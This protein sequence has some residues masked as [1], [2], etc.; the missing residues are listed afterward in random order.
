MTRSYNALFKLL[1]MKRILLVAVGFL[2]SFAA[3]AQNLLWGTSTNGG[4]NNNGVL[5][6][7]DPNGTVVKKIDFDSLNT[8][9][10]PTGSLVKAADGKLYGLTINGGVSNQ[11]VLFQYDPFTSTFSKK[12]DFNGIA[13][14]SKPM[15]QLVLAT[16]GKLYGMTTIGGTKNKGVV[17][18]FDPVTAILTKKID[19]EGT[20]NGAIPK[21]SLIQGN[22]GKLYG[23]T[24]AGGTSNKGVIFQYDL[25]SATLT[26]KF[27][28]T[29]FFTGAEPHGELLQAADGNLYG[30]TR[31]G[32]ASGKGI[33]FQY[34]LT[35]SAFTKKLD[36]NGTERG[37][38]PYGALIQ[39]NDGKLY[40]LTEDGGASNMGVIFQYDPITSTY[41]K[42]LNFN[43][44]DNGSK[45]SGSFLL[46]GDGKY[47]ATT[48][49][50]GAN[51]N[52]VLFQYDV[53]SL[54]YAKKADFSFTAT[55]FHPVDLTEAPDHLILVSPISTPVCAGSSLSITYTTYGVFNAG[56][57]FT[58][59]LSDASGSFSAATSIG[60]LTSTSS[61]AISA[62]VPSITPSGTAY[63]IRVI[64]ANPFVT[65]TD[66]GN[67]ITI[68]ALPAQ[69]GTFTISSASVHRGQNAVVYEVPSDPSATSY[70]WTYSGSGATINGSGNSVTI[71]FSLSAT[72]GT[73]T[74]IPSSN[75]CT[76]PAR[77]LAVSIGT[78]AANSSQSPY[79]LPTIPGGVFTALLTAGDVVSGYKMC[80][81]PDGTGA[82]D[83]ANGTFT[84]LMNHEFGNTA[85]VARAHGAKGAFVS[86]WIVN[87]SDL[88]V[89][90][91]SDLIQNVK[92]WNGSGYSTYNASNPSP[93]TAFNRFC[94][95]D[96]PAVSAF[97]NS[98]TGLG[99]QERIFMNGEE[100]GNE[101]RALA[102]IATG[103]EAGTTYELP[104]LGKLSWEN[105]VA[106]P[107]TGDK[108]LVA[109]LDDS[110][111][112]QVYFYIGT[113]TNSGTD[114][115]K[116]G[117]SN[118]KLFGIAVTG[119]VTETNAS[120]PSPDAPFTLA[121]LGQVQNLTGAVINTNSNNLGITTFLRPEDG[122][123]DPSHPGDFYFATTNAFNSPS[124]LWK[125]HF[126]DIYNPELGGTITAVLDGTEG[127]QMLDNL[128][129][130]NSGH[131]LL[132]EDV[133]GNA[134]LGKTW[135][136]TIATDE[137]KQVGTHDPTR[138]LNGAP[139]FLTQDE[140]A[141]GIVDVQSILGP[142]MFIVV[143][144]AHYGIA[145]EVVEGGQLLAYYNPDSYNASPL[146]F[147][148]TGG[149]NYC[150]GD[151]TGVEIG[152]SH[153]QIDVNYQ[154]IQNDSIPVGTTVSGSG[155]AI[156]FG[157]Q[158]ATGTYTVIATSTVNNTSANM[159][160][161]AVIVINPLPSVSIT[162]EGDTNI[163]AADSVLLA[164]IGGVSGS[165]YLW[166]N[167]KTT[168]SIY[169][170]TSGAYTVVL[171]DANGCSS[172][173][174]APLHITTYTLP[175]DFNNDGWVSNPDLSL[176]LLQ[177]G[178]TCTCITD[179]THDGVVSIGDLNL[180]LLVFNHNCI[181]FTPPQQ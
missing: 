39:A 99:T 113:K 84:I 146:V 4:A 134:H 177:Y 149:G 135:Q 148:V 54:T 131:I 94:S 27:D 152:L 159:N 130:D 42:K 70:N 154:L 8:G 38:E 14:G 32:G 153:S 147:N 17:F 51:G 28:F 37:A 30:L 174:S 171:T 140:E 43:G 66:N 141:S 11:G 104:Y 24:S 59:E 45:P 52:G 5:F 3:Q 169:A 129:I 79:L 20:S 110:T 50:G 23:M 118:G 145:G 96:L 80:G 143:D 22:D 151:T 47:Y 40:G 162:I 34:N 112:G 46:A 155:S 157:H 61:G 119:L 26:K 132:V 81:T 137:L 126:T 181:G 100:A 90:S 72:G 150:T 57:I 168:Q 158:T 73:L 173:S 60:T 67:D 179:L 1:F 7:Y 41:S 13:G 21:G 89:I 31:L 6:Q 2:L 19:F 102:H 83:N 63:R 163:C 122:A 88:S 172:A 55:G 105:S 161:N 136:Y 139:N 164:A 49:E 86:K 124:R 74:V 91:G 12:F 65:G 128:T 64:S 125:V 115:D 82:Y 69:P 87:K 101:G 85:G 44:I 29:G 18:Q 93:L 75:G 53:T 48:S 68:H 116:A 117:L 144:Q 25:V 58:A 108:T 97:Y 166:S 127:Q 15:G 71:D 175:E 170:H 98:A 95:A 35:T 121:D 107:F 123:W 133:G 156:S 167:N 111:P 178:M 109:G 106:C 62:T 138:F 36:F 16:D 180:L 142:G 9:K 92:L 56:T 78:T 77:T 10:N 76:G 160:G 114:I 165:T 103:P 120:V 33:L 176:L